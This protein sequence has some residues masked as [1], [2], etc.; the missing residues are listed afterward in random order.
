MT[1][2]AD[3]HADSDVSGT[4]DH[5]DEGEDGEGCCREAGRELTASRFGRRLDE[6]RCSHA[7]RK[8]RGTDENGE[9]APHHEENAHQVDVRFGR[10]KFRRVRSLHGS[11]API[12]SQAEIATRSSTRTGAACGEDTLKRNRAPSATPGGTDT[13]IGW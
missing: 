8:R 12:G 2:T 11:P 5:R 10:S 4:P 1:P 3:E 7:E 13:R 6:R 9:A